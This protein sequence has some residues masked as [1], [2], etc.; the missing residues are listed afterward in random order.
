MAAFDGAERDLDEGMR[1]DGAHHLVGAS[2]A[3]AAICAIDAAY[4]LLGPWSLPVQMAGT[5]L[6]VQGVTLVRRSRWN[7]AARRAVAP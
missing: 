6:V 7:V 5:A 2:L 1:A 4:M 3:L